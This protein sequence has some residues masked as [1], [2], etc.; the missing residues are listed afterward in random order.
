MQ[1]KYEGKEVNKK[2]KHKEK[3]KGTFFQMQN[4]KIK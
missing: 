1:D 3:S 4:A 2:K